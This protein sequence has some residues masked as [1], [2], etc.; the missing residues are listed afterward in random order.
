MRT[1]PRVTL[2]G[3]AA[4]REQASDLDL[5]VLPNAKPP[6]LEQGRWR[7]ALEALFTPHLMDLVV[8]GV[9]SSPIIRFE[10][11]RR[12]RY[13]FEAEPGLFSQVRRGSVLTF[14]HTAQ[15]LRSRPVARSLRQ[16][17]AIAAVSG[18]FEQ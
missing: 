8:L 12:G 14:Q 3:S 9:G 2:F 5:A 13:L 18:C 16:K 6:L 7:S 15:G 11:F 4:Y 10:V 1:D 17:D